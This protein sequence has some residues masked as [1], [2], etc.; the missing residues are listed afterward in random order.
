MAAGGALVDTFRQI[1]HLRDARRDFLAQQHAAAAGLGALPHHH[2]DRIG[3]AQVRQI[4]AVARGQILVDQR[5]EWPRSS[6]VMPPSPVVVEVPTAVAP[7]PSASL[8]LRGE[9]AEAHA[10]DGDGNFQVDRLFG[11]ARAQHDIGA[12]TLAIALQRI[13]RDRGAQ[14]QQIIEMR[15]LALR[16][17]AADIVNAGGGGALDFGDACADRRS[18]KSAAAWRGSAASGESGHSIGPGIVDVEMI[19]RAGGAIARE[20]LRIFSS[21]PACSN[22]V[23]RIAASSSVISFSSQSAPRLFTL[24]R[25]N[26]RAS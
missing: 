21:Q 1:A 7:R 26:I 11:E 6:G 18:R 17:A 19:Q 13:A 22:S 24:P 23:A 25:T 4:H 14:E 8:A 20:F 2:L 9:R 3:L 5:L 10:G 15:Q 12:A 16:A